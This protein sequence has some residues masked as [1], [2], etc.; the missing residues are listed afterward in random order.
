MNQMIIT[1]IPD[2]STV[3]ASKD[4]LDNSEFAGGYSAP[5]R[6]RVEY[7]RRQRRAGS[8]PFPSAS[9][10]PSPRFGTDAPPARWRVGP[11]ANARRIGC[12][13]HGAWRALHSPSAA[14]GCR[15]SRCFDG[16]C[17]LRYESLTFAACTGGRLLCA[18]NPMFRCAAANGNTRG[19]TDSLRGSSVIRH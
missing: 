5:D 11:L 16:R 19:R 7:N 14:R 6:F 13:A 8:V 10:W 2:D 12:R 15:L 9:L 18:S 1:S 4:C 17:E 3:A